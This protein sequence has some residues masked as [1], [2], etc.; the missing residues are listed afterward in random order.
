MQPNE[1]WNDTQRLIAFTV[2]VSFIAIIVIWLFH[3]PTGDAASNAVLNILMGALAAAFGAVIT[4]YF[5]SSKG[6]KDKD[7][8]ISS[9]ATHTENGNG[10]S[11]STATATATEPTPTKPATISVTTA[12]ATPNAPA[13]PVKAVP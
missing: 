13:S 4:F 6:S 7:D 5:G 12:P 1:S 9:I 11:G 8:T 3:A 2:V 10:G